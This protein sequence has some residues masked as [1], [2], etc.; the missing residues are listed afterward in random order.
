MFNIKDY[1]GKND[2]ATIQAAIDEAANAGGG[3]VFVPAGKYVCGSIILRDNITLEL[4]HGAEIVASDDASDY[5]YS[6]Y[7]P[8]NYSKKKTDAFVEKRFMGLICC[9]NVKNVTIKGGALVANDVSYFEKRELKG[10]AF[11]PALQAPAW[12]EYKISRERVAMILCENCE[13]LTFEDVRIEK[14]PAYAAWAIGC[15]TVRVKSVSTKGRK[16]L[17]NTDGF[18]FS[19]CKNV[20]VSSC[21]FECGDDCIAIDPGAHGQSRDVVVTGCVF[22]TSVHAVRIYTGIDAVA[23]GMERSVKNISVSACTVT[24]AAGILNINAQDGI[25]ENISMTD[26]TATLDAEGTSFL[27]SSSDGK[28]E[29]VRI[30]GLVMKGNGCGMIHASKKGEISRIRITDCEFVITP[31]TKLHAQ[32]EFMPLVFPR[33]CHFFPIAFHFERACDVIVKDI[34]LGW[35]APIYSDSWE[36]T[37][38]QALIEA[39][40]PTDISVLEPKHLEA[41][42]I[43]DCENIWIKDSVCP[44]FDVLG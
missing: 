33:H 37:R 22:N 12:Y 9:K 2:T 32:F 24:D 41:F 11:E 40:K 3:T 20:F 8:E 5:D 1:H 21:V 10:K 14:Y 7:F 35:T 44:D 27:I 26:V 23:N 25:I 15:D 6:I 34:R 16:D 30:S 39:I 28:V 13:N 36:S 42:K 31:K 17:I 19:E 18:H 43:I 29:N 38:K 4:S